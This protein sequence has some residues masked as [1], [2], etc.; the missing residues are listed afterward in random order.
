MF[1]FIHDLLTSSECGAGSFVSVI[2]LALLKYLPDYPHKHLLYQHVTARFYYLQMK[3]NV[4]AWWAFIRIT[5]FN[6]GPPD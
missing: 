2:C 5:E 1:N 4:L 6:E 3:V